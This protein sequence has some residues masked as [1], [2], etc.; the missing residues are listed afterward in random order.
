[1]GEFAITVQGMKIT[2]R[3]VGGSLYMQL[4]GTTSFYNLPLSELAGTSFGQSTDPGSAAD[5][6]A[7]MG[8]DTKKVGSETVHGAATTHYKGVI[9]VPKALQAAKGA[10]AKK[11]VQKLIDGGVSA[12]PAD[13]FLDSQGRLRR[14]IEHITLTVKGTKAESTTQLDLYDFGVKVNVQ[15][16]PASQIKDG[17]ELLKSIKA[18]AG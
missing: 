3:I 2:E 11:A 1:M 12:I 13:V 7:A 18:Q 10:L 14:L 15:K 16:P 4:P 5:L 6:L 8:D 17:T 9:S